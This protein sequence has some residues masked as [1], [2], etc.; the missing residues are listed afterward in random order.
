MVRYCAIF[1]KAAQDIATIT[2]YL[3][4]RFPNPKDPNAGVQLDPLS[5]IVTGLIVIATTVITEGAGTSMGITLAAAVTEMLGEG[6]KT[7]KTKPPEN[8]LKLGYHDTVIQTV[9]EYFD[10]V[11]Q[12]ERDVANAVNQLYDSLRTEVDK[13]R[14]GRTHEKSPGIGPRPER[15]PRFPDYL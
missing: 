4:E 12:I 1:D 11:A 3:T 13:L 9:H 14:Q 7:A 6:V 5:I 2:N 8:N 10:R 15:P